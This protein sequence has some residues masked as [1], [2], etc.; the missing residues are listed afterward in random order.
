MNAAE[1]NPP[2]PQ[3]AGGNLQTSVA[4][5]FN[6]MRDLLTSI[7][8]NDGEPGAAD[9]INDSADDGNGNDTE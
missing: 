3:G 5:L 2:G 1:G 8:L 7:H 9:D 4:S 6:A